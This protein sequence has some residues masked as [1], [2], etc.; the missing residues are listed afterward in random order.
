M[1]QENSR[2]GL[3]VAGAVLLVAL[4]SCTFIGSGQSGNSASSLATQMGPAEVLVADGV[5]PTPP[6]PPP[7]QHGVSA[8]QA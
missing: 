1:N 3:K 4:F 8:S 7:P 5:A 6:P 2:V